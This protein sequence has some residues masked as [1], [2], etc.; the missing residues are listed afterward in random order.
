MLPGGQY[1]QNH[2]V[3]AT[4]REMKDQQ[5]QITPHSLPLVHTDQHASTPVSKSS[6][7]NIAYTVRIA[8]S[9]RGIL[10]S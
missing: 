8:S 4:R 2:V 9:I 10:S 7:L 1:S 6:K 5:P 3:T